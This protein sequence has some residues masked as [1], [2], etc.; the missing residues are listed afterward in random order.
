[1]GLWASSPDNQGKWLSSALFGAIARHDRFGKFPEILPV[2]VVARQ[3]TE[4]KTAGAAKKSNKRLSVRVGTLTAFL[5]E[6][7]AI[8]EFFGNPP[9]DVARGVDSRSKPCHVTR[10][11]LFHLPVN[12]LQASDAFKKAVDTIGQIPVFWQ[13]QILILSTPKI[14]HIFPVNIHGGERHIDVFA[15]IPN[16]GMR[17]R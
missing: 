2:F 15:F 1:M 11:L 14:I 12:V 17:V 10:F 5:F 3:H 4:R 13:V 9:I 6:I 7:P 16:V 8:S